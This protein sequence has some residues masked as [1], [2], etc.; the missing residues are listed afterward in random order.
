METPTLPITRLDQ[1]DRSQQYS[2]ADYLRW[3]ISERLELICG[4]VWPMAAPNRRHQRILGKL[5]VD[6]ANFLRGKTCEV[7]QAPFDVRLPR[8]NQKTDE[9]VFTV[10]QPDLCV[11]CDPAK[12]DDAGCI[13]APDWVIEVLSKGNTKKEMRE[14]FAV[15]EASGVREYWVVQPEY[16]NVLVYVLEQGRFVARPVLTNDDT[17]V[18]PSVFP[19]LQ[20]DLNDVFADSARSNV[21]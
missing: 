4:Y 9:A 6:T 3:H 14:K 10:V 15:Y 11:I 1:I 21:E 8:Y 2:Y 16:N 7:Y 12:L 20:I 17:A 5:F 18:A 13:G 19:D